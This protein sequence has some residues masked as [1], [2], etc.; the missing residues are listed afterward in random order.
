[1]RPFGPN[2]GGTGKTVLPAV[3]KALSRVDSALNK[4]NTIARRRSGEASK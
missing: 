3:S 4:R 2:I 1:M